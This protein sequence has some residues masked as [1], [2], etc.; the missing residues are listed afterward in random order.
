MESEEWFTLERDVY[1]DD[2]VERCERFSDAARVGDW[3]TLH[4][5]LDEEEFAHLP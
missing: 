5:I 2:L 4:Q 3:A 1:R